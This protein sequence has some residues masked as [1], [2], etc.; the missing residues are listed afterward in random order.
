MS[1]VEMPPAAPVLPEAEVAE[2]PITTVEVIA[3]SEET[4][5]EVQVQVQEQQHEPSNEAAE[6]VLPPPQDP[7]PYAHIDHHHHAYANSVNINTNNNPPLRRGKWTPEESAYANR[8]IHEFKLGSLP[9]P[10]NITLREFLS[11]LLR[12]DPMRITKKFEG[13]NS[14]RK[15]V[16]KRLADARVIQEVRRGELAELERAFLERLEK[17]KANSSQA[18]ADGA[19]LASLQRVK[20]RAAEASASGTSEQQ[21]QEERAK[22]ND[23]VD[24]IDLFCIQH[25]LALQESLRENDGL[26]GG[27][28]AGGISASFASAAATIGYSYGSLENDNAGN[29]G[30]SLHHH[31][32]GSSRHNLYSNHD[33]TFLHPSR[34]LHHE[35]HP[36]TTTT[37]SSSLQRDLLVHLSRLQALIQGQSINSGNFAQDNHEEENGPA[38]LKKFKAAAASTAAAATNVLDQEYNYNLATANILSVQRMILDNKHKLYDIEFSLASSSPQEEEGVERK[39]EVMESI[40]REIGLLEMQKAEMER[41]IQNQQQQRLSEG[42]GEQQLLVGRIHDEDDIMEEEE[43]VDADARV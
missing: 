16:Y 33:D 32:S 42:D 7:P 28:G 19:L 39:R 20:E 41:E 1:S 31:K 22:E 10:N 43:G 6:V 25:D 8:L 36:S 9:L 2:E 5:H 34:Q 23:T 13:D 3:K 24:L 21:Q 35:Q 17:T 40:R 11:K 18:V 29:F 4:A 30:S 38:P 15:V 37:L 12:C 27:S 26:A 14:L